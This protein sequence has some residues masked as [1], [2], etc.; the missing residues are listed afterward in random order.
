MSTIGGNRVRALRFVVEEAPRAV[1]VH[2]VR[3]DERP[4]HRSFTA[5]QRRDTHTEEASV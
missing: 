3:V 1:A 2:A 5:A 4:Q